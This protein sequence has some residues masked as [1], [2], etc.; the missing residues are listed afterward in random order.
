M[1]CAA[2]P[3]LQ[4]VMRTITNSRF[5]PIV[6]LFVVFVAETVTSWIFVAIRIP[7]SVRS[8]FWPMIVE[9]TVAYVKISAFWQMIVENTVDYVKINAFRY[10][11][12][13]P[14]WISKWSITLQQHMKK[15]WF[16][17]VIWYKLL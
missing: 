4:I 8:H 16:K 2:L 7:G 6:K 17:Y 5:D 13:N 14:F 3:I 11:N 12:S 10:F 9:N 15:S 1:A